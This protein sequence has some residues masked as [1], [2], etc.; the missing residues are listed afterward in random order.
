MCDRQR[1]ERAHV[2]KRAT[3]GLLEKEGARDARQPVPSASASRRARLRCGTISHEKGEADE[4]PAHRQ[5]VA[6]RA[7]GRRD[8]HLEEMLDECVFAT[9]VAETSERDLRDDGAQL[10]R[11]GRDAVRGRA[12]ARRESLT[13]D[14]ERRRVGSEILAPDGS[15]SGRGVDARRWKVETVPNLEEVGH[16]VEEDEGAG[17]AAGVCAGDRT[18]LWRDERARAGGK[19]RQ[20]MDRPSPCSRSPCSR[21]KSTDQQKVTRTAGESG[22]GQMMTRSVNLQVQREQRAVT[23]ERWRPLTP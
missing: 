10:A 5:P 18:E 6:S 15:V 7:E 14:D 16:A 3:L 22:N 23:G 8:S 11:G 9:P 13:G 12:V 21:L 1:T 4:P 17:T 19:Q 2:F 20:E